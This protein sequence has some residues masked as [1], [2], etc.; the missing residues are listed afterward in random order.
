MRAYVTYGQWLC[1]SPFSV[2]GVAPV[3]R[4]MVRTAESLRRTAYHESG[5]AL[6]AFHTD[7]AHP[8][9]KA[10][11][12]PRGHTLGM[13]QQVTSQITS[14]HMPLAHLSHQPQQAFSSRTCCA[15]T[16]SALGG[17]CWHK[18]RWHRAVPA[19]RGL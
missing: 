15:H 6:V 8:I 3:C 11:I 16:T 9:H 7:G 13:V 4:S 2:S 18:L 5:H 10:T 19:V 14:G 12:V 1:M 17:A